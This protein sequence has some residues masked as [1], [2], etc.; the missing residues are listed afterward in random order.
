M[1]RRAVIPMAVQNRWVVSSLTQLAEGV[2]WGSAGRT[3]GRQS[4]A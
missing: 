4:L 1:A 2:R 3:S